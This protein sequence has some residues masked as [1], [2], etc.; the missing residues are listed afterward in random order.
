VPPAPSTHARNEDISSPKSLARKATTLEVVGRPKPDKIRVELN[1]EKWPGIWQPAK[2]RNKQEL[3]VFERQITLEDGTRITARLEVSFTH[4]GTLTTEERR[5]Y[6]VLI[7]Q[8]ED[9]GKKD[10]PVFFSARQL[11]RILGK[12]WGTNVID[13]ITKSLRRLR[14]V[15][16]EW[17]NAYYDTAGRVLRARQPM[18]F[19][20]DLKIIESAEDGAVNSA[21]GYFQF[22]DTLLS[23]L[24]SNLTKPFLLDELLEI[25]T[26]IGL[27][28]YGHLDLILANKYRYERCTKELFEDLG[29]QNP[30]YRFMNKRKRALEMSMKELVGRRISTGVIA[31]ATIEKTQDKK[32]YKIIVQKASS[33]ARLIEPAVSAQITPPEAPIRHKTAE[34]VEQQ[35]E[36][37]VRYFH[38]KFHNVHR[39]D[40]YQP[41]SKELNQATSLIAT[42]GYDQ[43]R[44]VVDF[45]H[46]AAKVTKYLPQTFGGILQYT[47]RASAQ[48]EEARLARERGR[49][50][51]AQRAE[52]ERLER[53][54][55][56]YV[57]KAVDAYLADPAN[58]TA[59]AVM[60]AEQLV[61]ARRKFPLMTTSQ[62]E[63][64]ANNFMRQELRNRLG[65]L[66]FDDFVAREKSAALSF[67]AAGNTP[68]IIETE[69]DPE[70]R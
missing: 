16:L 54:H 23:N 24:L 10:T 13:S 53:A 22:D 58:E 5:M 3:R 63:D 32:D 65:L 21:K 49:L 4:L 69:P 33:R 44:Y 55:N 67:A 59:K 43:A 51:A 35:A 2:S 38:K 14:T 47:S 42:H 36:E 34:L 46:D 29:L 64:F 56:A 57:Q 1:I 66:S 26:E 50:V 19:L 11:A 60:L 41:R 31:T 40:Q 6:C 7:K 18:T 15:P 37:I 68:P 48:F 45:S 9:D 17:V 8:W 39:V 12:G 25:K 30:D 70:Q 61:V 20:A 52:R 27:L 62:Q 28:L